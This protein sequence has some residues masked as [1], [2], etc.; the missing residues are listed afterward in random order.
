MADLLRGAIVVL[1][2]CALV[3]SASVSIASFLAATAIWAVLW[4]GLAAA[5]VALIGAVLWSIGSSLR[6][7]AE[8]GK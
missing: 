3:F 2:V 6:I 8:D 4:G 5:T 7:V 1:A